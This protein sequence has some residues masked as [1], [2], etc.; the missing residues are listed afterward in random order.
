MNFKHLT[1][2]VLIVTMAAAC[3]T[4]PPSS[5]WRPT[6]D[7]QGGMN[8]AQYERDLADCREFAEANP[9]AD[10]ETAA[11]EGARSA[12]V[13]QGVGTAALIG[14]AGLLTGGV[15]LI[16]MALGGLFAGATGGMVGGYVGNDVADLKYRNIVSNCMIGRGY[17]VL[18]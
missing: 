18:G 2:A 10:P 8:Q 4:T 13:R 14:A 16:P 11:R 6:V 9:E 15:A 17:R 12:A 3:A 1:P 5:T 7:T